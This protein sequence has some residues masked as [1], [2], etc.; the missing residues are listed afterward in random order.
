MTD[1]TNLLIGLLDYIEQVEKL[2]RK[3]TYVVPSDPFAAYQTEIKGLPGIQFNLQSE[4]EDIWLRILRQNEISAPEPDEK[5]KP[6]ISISKS[7]YKQPELKT[8]ITILE[9]KNE[10]GRDT[11]ENNPNI[12]RYFKW[13]LSDLWEPW[14]SAERPRRKAIAFYNKLFT[15]QQAISIDGIETPLELAWGMGCAVWKKDGSATFINHPLITQTCEILLNPKSL[16]LEIRP[17]VVDPRIELDCY[18]DLEIHGVRPLEG[19]WKNVIESAAD[20]V[21][22]FETSTYEGVLKAAVGHLDPQGRYLTGQLEPTLPATDENLCITDTWVVFARK[23]SEHI[24]IKDI[25]ELKKK[26]ASTDSIPAVIASFVKSGATTIE[27]HEPVHFRGLSSSSSDVGIRDLFFP[28]PYNEEQVSIIEKLETNDGVVVQGPPGTGKTHTIA[29]VICHFL[30]QGKRV[31]VTSKGDT[32]LA[33]LQEKLPEQIRPLSV[34]LRN[35]SLPTGS[36]SPN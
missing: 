19:F 3:A 36:R 13:Y 11:L 28:L 1:S 35:F 16:D 21:N 25:Q 9:D 34:S 6:W 8:E 22:P 20:R 26:I 14:A 18:A 32:A 4:G 15:V 30:A 10:V 7:P 2:K 12:Q 27:V 5:L 33:V 31:L 17:R 24:F 23:R 29:N